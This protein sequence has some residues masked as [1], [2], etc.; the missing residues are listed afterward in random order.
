MIDGISASALLSVP[1]AS[2]PSG[3]DSPEKIHSAAQQ[4]E[5]LLISQLLKSAREADGGGWMGTDED[6]AGQVRVEMGE[7]QF[8]NML[9]SSGGL[10]LGRLIE[11][12]LKKE[13]E[14]AQSAAS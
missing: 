13:S 9:A 5:S 6:D 10:G 1:G 11:S 4:F 8:A 3:G 2:V 12:G 7:Q 14:K